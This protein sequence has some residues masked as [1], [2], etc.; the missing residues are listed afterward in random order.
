MADDSELTVD[1]LRQQVEA[2]H[3]HFY[4]PFDFGHGIVTRPWHVKRRFRR[5]L[6]ILQIPKDLTGK[7]VLDIG[8]WDG[9]FSFEFERRGAKRVMAIDADIWDSQSGRA[10]ECFKLAHRQFKSRVEYRRLDVHE[11]G[12]E[13]LGTFDLVFCAGVLY[14]VRHPLIALEHIRSV[15]AGTLI[16]ETASLIPA[17][18]ESA[19]LMTFYP[20]D[21]YIAALR[22]KG[23][24]PWHLGGYP[25]EEWLRYALMT[26]GFDRHKVVYR[27][28]YKWAKKL[29]ALVTN[30]PRT[31]RLIVHA[32][33]DATDG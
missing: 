15:T 10:L 6:S 23:R 18:H 8:A 30:R 14:H 11:I 27:P 9:Y 31:G 17:M 21:L 28:S 1:E 7:T 2:L 5:R 32:H 13:T 19:P 12:P 3:G 29:H 24:F 20:G 26:A 16:L 22:A 33:V 4:S 25:T